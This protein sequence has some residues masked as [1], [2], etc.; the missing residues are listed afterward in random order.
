MA[1]AAI[2]A[3]FWYA[4]GMRL[5][6]IHRH[7]DQARKIRTLLHDFEN[8]PDDIEYIPGS[9]GRGQARKAFDR[10]IA[11]LKWNEAEALRLLLDGIARGGG[12]YEGARNARGAGE[13]ATGVGRGR[14]VRTPEHR[15]QIAAMGRAQAKRAI[16]TR[17]PWKQGGEGEGG[18]GT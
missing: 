15:A 4:L 11:R 14:Y 1:C 10:R 12:G 18:D 9:Y 3:G 7:L 17:R 2:L 6:Q 13:R 5:A 16:G 8:A